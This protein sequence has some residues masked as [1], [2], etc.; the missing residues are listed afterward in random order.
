MTT[1]Y[2]TTNQNDI[3]VIEEEQDINLGDNIMKDNLGNINEISKNNIKETKSSEKV[4][5]SNIIKKRRF[6]PVYNTDIKYN[7]EQ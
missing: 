1:K 2:K 4:N 5:N 7:T 3:H 6:D